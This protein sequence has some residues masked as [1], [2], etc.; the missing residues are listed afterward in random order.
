MVVIDEY[1][2]QCLA[3]HVTRRIRAE[4]AFDVFAEL[5]QT[6]DIA[7]H[8]RSD[9]GPVSVKWCKSVLHSSWELRRSYETLA[10]FHTPKYIFPIWFYGCLLH[11]P[12]AA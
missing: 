11:S 2:R 5:M 7:E 12:K 3:I 10:S 9:N 8:I 1:T 6:H 4:D